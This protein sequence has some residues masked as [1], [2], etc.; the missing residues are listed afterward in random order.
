[1]V[2]GRLK[3]CEEVITIINQRYDQ[4]EGFTVYRKT[5]V[6][7]ASWYGSLK[8]TVDPSGLKAANQYTV[9]IPIDADFGGK[10]YV[11]PVTYKGASD[12]QAGISFT[13]GNGDLIVHGE[14]SESDAN[15]TPKLVHDNYAEV[16]TILAVNDNRRLR[17]SSHWKVVGA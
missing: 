10:I 6:R 2:C 13:L 3:L 1:M 16:L 4:E 8:S 17:K 14:V 12:E 9:R 7:G 15:I 11:N 5:I